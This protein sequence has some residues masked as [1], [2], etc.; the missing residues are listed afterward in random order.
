M[1]KLDV[2]IM[3]K[4][5]KLLT[6]NRASKAEDFYRESLKILKKSRVPFLI[7]GTFAINAY[8]NIN[9]PTVDMDIF[10]KPSDFPR[11][12]QAFAK[13][14]YKTEILD[15]RWLAKVYQGKFYFD[16]IFSSPNAISPVSDAWFENANNFKF[17]D[18][19]VK[20][21]PVTELFWAKAFT[22]D[23]DK[24]DGPDI[25]HLI[26]KQHAQID[27]Q[28][29]LKY[30]DQYWE[31]LLTHILNFRFVYPSER[32]EIPRWLL[33]E[34]LSRL[35]SQIELPTSTTKICRGRLFS[36]KNYEIDLKEW[37]FADLIGPQNESK[38]SDKK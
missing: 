4:N 28:R 25:T 13:Q 22:Q 3:D 29:L 26:L 35:H 20:L 1:N 30:F 7:G 16:I 8:T 32:E 21:L 15:E 19:E 14:G 2:K 37:G 11:I 9:R 27:W 10:C 24:Y 5:R 34:L 12:L 17:Y 31:V 23:R 18:V 6:T 36:L 38:P 33:N